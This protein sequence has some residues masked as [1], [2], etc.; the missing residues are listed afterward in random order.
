MANLSLQDHI[1][2][3]L[4]N[5]AA[6][7]ATFNGG[8]WPRIPQAGSGATA[9]PGAFWGAE[10]PGEAGK[11]KNTI[12]VLDGGDDPAPNGAARDGY[13]GFPLV[14]GFVANTT[15]GRAALMQLEDRLHFRFN[16]H[17]TYARVDGSAVIFQVLERQP[18]QD[19]DE[20]GYPGRIFT[21]WRV[22]G[23]YVRI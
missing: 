21:T 10:N 16:R 20:F 4:K 11:L 2:F 1:I 17:V 15:S 19:G 9:T 18:Q 5:E 14:R 6:L 12:S 23:T 7:L 3:V 13:V 22:Q 8:V